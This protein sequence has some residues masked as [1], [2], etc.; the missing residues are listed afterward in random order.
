MPEAEKSPQQHF[1]ELREWVLATLGTGHPIRQSAYQMALTANVHR[2]IKFGP[3]ETLNHLTSRDLMHLLIYTN[4]PIAEWIMRSAFTR[5]LI[6]D[7][8]VVY[9][10]LAQS[11]FIKECSLWYWKLVEGLI[12]AA[13]DPDAMTTWVDNMPPEEKSLARLLIARVFPDTAHTSWLTEAEAFPEIAYQ[14]AEI[15]G[16]EE[17]VDWV[18]ARP[19]IRNAAYA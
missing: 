8:R 6:E 16:T 11:P 19:N 9:E 1:T 14:I 18:K 10:R 3:D 17:A 13:P 12:G 15:I 2:L 4:G 7:D 5:S